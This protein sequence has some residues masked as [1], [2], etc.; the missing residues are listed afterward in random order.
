MNLAIILSGGTGSRIGTDLPKQFLKIGD[1]SV[2]EY[3][4]EAFE[5]HNAID[6]ILIVSNAYYIQQTEAII[7][8]NRYKKVQKVIQGG[9]TRQE[10]SFTG[11]FSADSKIKNVLIH[12]AARPFVSSALIDR[13]IEGLSIHR[14][15]VPAVP[16]P[17]TLIE[18]D[19]NNII[20]SIPDRNVI[21]RV[22]TPQAFDMSLIKKAHKMAENKENLNV[23][24]D[25]SLILKLDLADVYVIEGSIDNIKIT[26]PEDIDYAE[27][28][29][30]KWK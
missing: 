14:A 5:N 3:S 7:N 24:D 26:Y 9:K 4:I 29:I 25:G 6:Q 12:D 16:S 27:A 30:K 1:K 21:Q 8:K 15:V 13:L 28:F 2:I 11:V 22:Q 23:T 17:D 18:K 10:S 19:K 20:K